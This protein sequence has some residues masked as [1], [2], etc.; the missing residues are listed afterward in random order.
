MVRHVSGSGA[1]RAGAVRLV[2]LEVGDD[3]A[4]WESA[5]F[6]VTDGSVRL[7]ATRIRLVGTGAGDGARGIRS[8]SLAGLDG[9]DDL[10]GLPTRSVGPID[11]DAD[12]EAD[13]HDD[14]ADG[15][16]HANGTTGLDHVVV[17]TPDLDR[18]IA[19]LAAVGLGVRRIRETTSN[20]APMRQAFI[21]LGPTILEV[22]SGDTGQGA[23]A[24]DAPSTWFGLAVDVAD[25]DALAL[26]LGPGLGRVRPAVQAGRR[27]ATLRHRDLGL[28]V[29]VACMDDHGDR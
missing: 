16:A 22:V 6:T 4:A 24:A 17:L 28:S 26:R 2:E 11:A 10:D 1:V 7:G 18:T 23:P 27:I 21:R 8:W 25:L 5:G 3:P 13:A 15:A 20:G 12:A 14:G 9:V 19:A 29:A